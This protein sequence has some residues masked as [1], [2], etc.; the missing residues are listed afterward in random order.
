MRK[1][2]RIAQG[3]ALFFRHRFRQ[4]KFPGATHVP[5]RIPT[6]ERGDHCA[7]DAS[8]AVTLPLGDPDTAVG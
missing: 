2:S 3:H 5:G 4:W 6:D 1:E 8:R 7:F